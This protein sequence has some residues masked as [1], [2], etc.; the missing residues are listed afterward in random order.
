MFYG[1]RCPLVKE[2]WYQL[3]WYKN[4]ISVDVKYGFVRRGHG[5]LRA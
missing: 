5:C 1:K 2:K 4:H 3:F